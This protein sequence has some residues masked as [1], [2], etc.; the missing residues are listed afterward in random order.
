MAR[1]YTILASEPD[2]QH[3]S[4]RLT[5][6]IESAEEIEDLIESIERFIAEDFDE[7]DNHEITQG[8]YDD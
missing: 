6:E 4:D 8:E 1:K 5:F 7:H 3:I 2:S